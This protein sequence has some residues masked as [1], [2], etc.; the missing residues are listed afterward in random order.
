MR[1]TMPVPPS[2]NVEAMMIGD[3]PVCPKLSGMKKDLR[4][5]LFFCSS[6]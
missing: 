2:K 5:F 1:T 6:K 3:E 4:S